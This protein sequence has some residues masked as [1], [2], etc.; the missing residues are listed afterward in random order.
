[1]RAGTQEC[2]LPRH[3]SRGGEFGGRTKRDFFS[4]TSLTRCSRFTRDSDLTPLCETEREKT[5]RRVLP[6]QVV[7]GRKQRVETL[8][9]LTNNLK[10]A[11][12]KARSVSAQRFR[13]QPTHTHTHTLEKSVCEGVRGGG[14]RSCDDTQADM[15]LGI[16]KS[17]SCVQRFDDSL[18]SAIHI[19]YR[20]LLRSSSMHEPR[21]PPLKVVFSFLICC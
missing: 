8:G 2:A 18:I 7:V 19:T 9:S 13:P 20:S 6:H 5:D 14:M 11:Q 15:L 17:A 12:I 3:G 4:F 16:P 10:A 1:V 21:D